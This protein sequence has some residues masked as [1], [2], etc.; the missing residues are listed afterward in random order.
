MILEKWP[1]TFLKMNP[2]TFS[3]AAA[4]LLPSAISNAAVL[5]TVGVYDATGG[6]NNAV[7]TDATGTLATFTSTVATAYTAGFGGVA[8]FDVGAEAITVATGTLDLSYAYVAGSPTKTMTLTSSVIGTTA[9][10]A[11]ASSGVA[12]SGS[13][14]FNRATGAS[15]DT[16]YTFL[17]PLGE[18][19][20]SFAF[21]LLE[22]NTYAA[23]GVTFTATAF[24]SDGT[25]SGG[26][27]S[28]VGDINAGTSDKGLDDTFWSFNAPVGHS[29]TSVFLDS[30]ST[31]ASSAGQP[32]IDDFAFITTAGVIIPEPSLALLGAI[33][34]LV[35]LR[36]KR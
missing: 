15:P 18:G 14:V 29:I 30:S 16:T 33:G 11:G 25:N 13:T 36:R 32:L 7:D 8:N 28:N 3:L 20:T 27:A 19:V 22:R 4:M 23:G 6:M 24:F 31:T 2:K 21:T 12:I 34:G 1:Y 17:A 26:I 5:S 10:L 35:F 9:V